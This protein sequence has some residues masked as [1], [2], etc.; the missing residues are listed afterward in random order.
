MLNFNCRINIKRNF[1]SFKFPRPLI[2]LRKKFA[3]KLFVLYHNISVQY[4]KILYIADYYDSS[5][6]LL[7]YPQSR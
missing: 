1:T 6:N 2:C 5:E 4:K 3:S 7:R